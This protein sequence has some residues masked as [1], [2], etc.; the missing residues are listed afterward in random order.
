MLRSAEGC[1]R[2]SLGLAEAVKE[3]RVGAGRAAVRGPRPGCATL[4][5][6]AIGWEVHEGTWSSPGSAIR[7]QAALCELRHGNAVRQRQHS[8]TG[9]GGLWGPG[10]SGHAAP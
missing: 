4:A 9:E 6:L 5:A 8:A 1:S 2:P 7:G 3:S 10:G